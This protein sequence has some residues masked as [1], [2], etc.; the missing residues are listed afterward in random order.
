MK[1]VGVTGGIGSGKS[2]VCEVL[3]VLGVPVFEA[4]REA[5]LLYGKPEVRNA[6]IATF[7]EAMYVGDVLDRHMMATRVFTD[8][9]ALSKLN[10][11]IHPAVRKRFQEWTAE[12]HAPYVVMEAAILAETGG[13][14][15]FDHLVVVTAPEELRIRRVMKRDGVEEE[16]VRSRMRH[17]ASEEER[18]K[19]ADTVIVNDD[20]TLVIPQV[21]DLHQ[22]LCTV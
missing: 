15:A 11:I 21:L 19:L 5:K 6:V 1:K 10:A 20:R 3:R 13:A 4:D 18:L 17:Q 2:T 16:A 22:R 14:K 9:A 12:Q 7:G 8:P